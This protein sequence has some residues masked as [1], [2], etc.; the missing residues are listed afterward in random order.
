MVLPD[1]AQVTMRVP[2][3]H[4]YSDLLV[5]TCHMRGA[6]AIGGMS[7]FIPSRR[8]A[9]VNER[10]LAQVTAD[11][12][13]EAGAGFDG[14]WVAHPDLVPVA[15]RCFDAVLGERPDQRERMR[16]DVEV[17]ADD[18]LGFAIE[19]GTVSEA[20]VR[21]NVSIAIRYIASWLA[22]TGA[23]AIDNLMEDAA[24]AEISR[25]QLWQ[26][27]RHGTRLED[28][29]TIDAELYR[30]IRAEE[31]RALPDDAPHHQA[32][33]LLDRLVLSDDFED[34]LTVPAYA[35]LD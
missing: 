18:L 24:T 12:E 13:R 19:G 2:F 6:H 26:W 35:L 5:R 14:T 34:F 25:A 16:E 8:D 31:S 28:G 20:G 11:K 7:A 27:R 15:L 32:A 1:R 33:E 22:G 23:A 17:G 10:A 9:E 21:S 30:A 4:A 29:R 3:M